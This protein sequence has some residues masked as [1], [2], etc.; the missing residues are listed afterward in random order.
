MS[1]LSSADSKNTIK[2]NNR[3]RSSSSRKAAAVGPISGPISGP[4]PVPDEIE[5]CSICLES[6][7]G[8]KK[9]YETECHHVF[10]QN[11]LKTTCKTH[12]V[13]PLCRENI[14]VDCREIIGNKSYEMP[15]NRIKKILQNAK[16]YDK[17]N[18]ST[19]NKMRTQLLAMKFPKG[20]DFDKI[21][22]FEQAFH[23][24]QT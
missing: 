8:R 12:N 6:L 20:T 5:V 21:T 1:S 19:I 13:C 2:R 15:S 9:K 7:K 11:C 17:K 24:Q 3:T 23:A 4:V 16:E 14:E 22:F 10:H 18:I